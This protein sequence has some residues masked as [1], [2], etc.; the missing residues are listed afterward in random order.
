MNFA[1]PIVMLSVAIALPAKAE[2]N[3][4]LKDLGA[5]IFKTNGVV[6]EIN[7][8][9]SK[10][11]DAELKILVIGEKLEPVRST[12]D[13]LLACLAAAESSLDVSDS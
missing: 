4:K 3:K 6:S 8:N 11:T 9:R 5:R 12:V 13:D 2:E 1:Y 10:I 7:L